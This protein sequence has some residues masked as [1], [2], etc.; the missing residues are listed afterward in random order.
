MNSNTI[1]IMGK[2]NKERI[3]PM[4]PKLKESINE[5][6]KIKSQKFNNKYHEHLFVSKSGIAFR[7]ICL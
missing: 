5:Y 6:L 1:R 4:L 3:I 7:K 2:R